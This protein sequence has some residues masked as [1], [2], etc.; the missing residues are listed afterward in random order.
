MENL[1]LYSNAEKAEKDNN[2][3]K[4]LE[5]Y[6]ELLKLDYTIHNLGKIGWC[7]S[8][9]SDYKNSISFFKKCI[10]LDSKNAKWFYMI[11]YQYYSQKKFSESLEWFQQSINLYPSY[12]NAK[13]RI[14]YAYL[15]IAG[16]FKQLTK[17]EFWKAIDQLEQCHLI[18]DQFNEDEKNK[19]K[20]IY[21]DICCLHG[22]TISRLDNYLDKALS[23]LLKAHSIKEEENNMYQISKIYIKKMDY[24]SAKNYLPK[25]NKYY[26]KELE[27]DIDINTKEYDI[28]LEKI[29]KLLKTRKKDYIYIKKAKIYYRK[30]DYKEAYKNAM[31]AINFNSNN[32]INHYSLAKIAYTLNLY[33]LALK[34]FKLANQLKIK[35][36]GIPFKECLDII[37]YIETNNLVANKDDTDLLNE[38][39][40]DKAQCGIINHYNEKKGFGFIES[41]NQRVF[42]HISNC[43]FSKARINGKVTFTTENTQ[44]GIIAVNIK[45]I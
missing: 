28:A 2:W 34:E 20:N 3:Q 17:T 35:S 24:V 5:L 9:L 21:F 12:L 15:Q 1:E 19:N 22:K 43:Q 4:A 10:V 26:V 8:R 37:K 6:Q 29:N 40:K 25:S 44:K 11:G 18:W 42:F 32:H 7:F 14:S 27:I 36:F 39:N 13:Y 31:I 16:T 23:L 38:L 41:N 30:D 45:Y 33:H